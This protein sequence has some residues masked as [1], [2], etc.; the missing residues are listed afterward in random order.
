MFLMI[1][2]GFPAWITV[3]I[4]L[5]A[6]YILMDASLFKATYTIDEDGIQEQL[7]PSKNLFKALQTQQRTFKWAD[8]KSYLLDEDMTRYRGP[9]KFLK[10]KFHNTR[11][12]FHISEGYEPT[13]KQ[14]FATFSEA[15]VTQLQ[16]VSPAVQIDRGF[17]SRPI[18][19]VLSLF[20]LLVSICLVFLS[21]VMPLGL[22][23][24]FKL[25]FIII[26]GTLYMLHRSLRGR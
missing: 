19:K 10:I 22:G 23:G 2:L 25:G 13:A 3:F 16:N 11:Y 9:Q 14:Q 1:Y 24:A 15:F 18:A 8:I 4:F 12:R 6:V 26:P 7:A 5:A 17:Y 21:F 20:F